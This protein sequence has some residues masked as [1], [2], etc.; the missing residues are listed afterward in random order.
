MLKRHEVQ[1]TIIQFEPTIQLLP[2]VGLDNWSKKMNQSDFRE[3]KQ[4]R[5]L[6]QRKHH[7]CAMAT[8]LRFS[9]ILLVY[10]IV[11]KQR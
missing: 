10:Y 6:R 1:S 7:F 9:Y 3:F 8:I 4:P 5:R 2:V 11:D